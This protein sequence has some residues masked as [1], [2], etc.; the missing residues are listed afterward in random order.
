MHGVV[1]KHS[2]AAL[3]RAF[4][5]LGRPRCGR[6]PTELPNHGIKAGARD[7]LHCEIVQPV[8]F[9]RLVNGDDIGVVQPPGSARLAAESFDPARVDHRVKHQHLQ[10]DATAQR[11]LLG[12][13]DNSHAAA[14]NLAQ[15]L[16]VAEPTRQRRGADRRRP[17][18]RARATQPRNHWVA[19]PV[20]F[21][22]HA[23]ALCAAFDVPGDLF[24][25]PFGERTH[26]ERSQLVPGRAFD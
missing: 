7:E 4:R 2:G 23:V 15:N 10:G 6:E 21:L 11:N 1:E 24:E 13:V 19:Q 14:A 20:E 26:G 17:G 12:L 16:E 5:G 9:P 8:L 25:R 3:E 22:Q 18:A